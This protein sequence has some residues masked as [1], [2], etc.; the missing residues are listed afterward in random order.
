MSRL[1]DRLDSEQLA[2]VQFRTSSVSQVRA[3]VTVERYL[4]RHHAARAEHSTLIG[5]PKTSSKV[6]CPRKSHP[7]FS[8][9]THPPLKHR[10]ICWK[11]KCYLFN[12]RQHETVQEAIGASKVRSPASSGTNAKAYR[13]TTRLL[14]GPIY[15]AGCSSPLPQGT[16]KGV[17]VD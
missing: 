6:E 9:C 7:A 1:P 8:A 2:T 13:R 12:I 16:R 15:L 10:T 17:Q 11:D 5:A 4:P 3:T 14:Q